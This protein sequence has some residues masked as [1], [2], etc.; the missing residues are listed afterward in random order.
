MRILGALV[1]TQSTGVMA[2]AAAQSIERCAVRREAVGHKPIRREAVF[3]KQLPQQSPRCALVAALLNQN[4][5]NFTFGIDCA[6]HEHEF[7]VDANDHFIEMPDR[8][9]A[10]AGSTNIGRND[11]TKFLCPTPDRLV[12]DVNPA[13]GENLLHIP[14]TQGEFEYNQTDWRITS[15]GKRGLLYEMACIPPAYIRDELKL[16]CPRRDDFTLD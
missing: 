10:R 5:E 3:S 4:V 2:R 6:P 16:D 1:V 12:G 11:A 9:R 15:G 8:G 7:A 14:S 13:L